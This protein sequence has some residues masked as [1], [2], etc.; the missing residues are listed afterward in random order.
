MA[1]YTNPQIALLAAVEYHKA[2]SAAKGSL[3]P[4]T[5]DANEFLS[6]LNASE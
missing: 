6:W 3:R 5:S 2:R 1:E 4:V